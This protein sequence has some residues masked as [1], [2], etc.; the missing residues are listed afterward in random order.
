MHTNISSTIKKEEDHLLVNED[1]PFCY[2]IRILS[3][4]CYSWRKRK[5]ENKFRQTLLIMNFFFMEILGIRKLYL[6]TIKSS[7]IEKTHLRGNALPYFSYTIFFILIAINDNVYFFHTQYSNQKYYIRETNL[8]I[9]CINMRCC[10]LCVFK[11]T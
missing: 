4:T 7:Q 9:I 3:N 11:S 8:L 10:L 6:T 1:V 5:S 2:R